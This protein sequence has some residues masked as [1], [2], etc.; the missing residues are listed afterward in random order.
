[1]DK[2]QKVIK[3]NQ[4]KYNVFSN[5]FEEEYMI[6]RDFLVSKDGHPLFMYKLGITKL[7]LQ[8]Y[9]YKNK[10]DPSEWLHQLGITFIKNMIE[11]HDFSKESGIV[12]TLEMSKNKFHWEK[13]E[14]IEKNK[15]YTQ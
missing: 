15:V 13:L 9:N 1:M 8:I 7:A 6:Y 3:I 4:K 12:T 14:P 10:F 11:N 5:L 2:V